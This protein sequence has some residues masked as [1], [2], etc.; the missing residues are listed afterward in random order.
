MTDEDPTPVANSTGWQGVSRA[1]QLTAWIQAGRANHTDAALERSALASG[2]TAEEFRL[3]ADLASTRDRHRAA[4]QPIRSNAQR[5]ILAAY[6]VVWLLFAIPYLVRQTQDAYGP[7]LQGIL[8]LSLLIG[9]GI[10]AVAIRVLH[11]N[12][13]NVA[14]AMVIL[15]V[16]PAIT[17]VAITGLCLPFVG[18]G[19]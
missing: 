3:A 1:D 12:P 13:D 8:T 7:F 17:L 11:P 10:S 19:S 14:R 5:W 2:Y 4:I 18:A 6:G 9:L 15:L 16:V